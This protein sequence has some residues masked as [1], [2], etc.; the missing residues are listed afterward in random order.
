MFS[1]EKEFWKAEVNNRTLSET[2]LF[3]MQWAL[4]QKSSRHLKTKGFYILSF[5]Y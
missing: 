2:F 1:T 4:R 3:I 5:L